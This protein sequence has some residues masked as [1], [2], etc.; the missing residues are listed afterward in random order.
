MP[1]ENATDVAPESTPGNP[2]PTPAPAPAPEPKP[3]PAAAPAPAPADTRGWVPETL[4]GHKSLEKFKT[5]A[6][7]AQAYA[8]L[9]GAFGKKFEEHLKPDADPEIRARVRSALGV[10]EAPNGYE[11]PPVPEGRVLDANITG[12]FKEQAHKLGISKSAAKGL[13]EWYLGMELER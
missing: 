7:V 3:A 4:R 13:M 12:G 11:D 1:N 5:P 6:D 10:P 9:E 2:A 8:N